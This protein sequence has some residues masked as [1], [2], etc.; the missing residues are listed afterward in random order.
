MP[1]RMVKASFP[2]KEVSAIK[3]YEAVIALK[4]LLA[5]LEVP[6]RFPIN[7]EALIIEAV[8]GIFVIAPCSVTSCNVPKGP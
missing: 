6:S 4:E 7:V 3:A 5:Q 1:D 8:I 2:S